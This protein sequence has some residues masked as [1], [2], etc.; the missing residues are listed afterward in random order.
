MQLSTRRFADVVVANPTGRI[1]Y[2]NAEDFKS[3]LW[4]AL[5]AYEAA[6][7]NGAG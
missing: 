4:Q 7:P 1:D 5:A 6:P 3:A 2:T